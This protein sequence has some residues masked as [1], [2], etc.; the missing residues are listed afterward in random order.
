MKRIAAHLFAAVLGL[1]LASEAATF[2]YVPTG[3][4]NDLAIIDVKTDK[5]V[6]RIPE[7]ENAH[8]LAGSPKS[9]Y[10]VAGS[11]QRAEAAVKSDAKKPEA[12]SEAEHAAHHAADAEQFAATP[13]SQISLVDPLKRNVVRR[14]TVRGLTHHTAVTPDGNYAVAVHSGAGGISVIDLNSKAVVKE[15]QTGKSPN[16]AIFDKDGSHLFV[17]NAFSGNV[18]EITTSNWTIART[19]QT[20]KEPEHMVLSPDESKL[21]VANVADGQV[22]AIDLASGTVSARYPV[23][24]GVHGLDVSADGQTLVAASLSGGKLVRIDVTTGK[25]HVT[26]LQP[27]PYHVEMLDDLGKIYVSSRKEPKIWIVDPRSLEVRGEISIGQGVA[28]QMVVLDR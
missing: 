28:H 11:M 16:Y 21:Y 13:A 22:A 18:S 8:G 24:P 9:E 23:G 25:E 6:G 2:M 12:I 10:L 27:A 7:I 1:P 15:L 19:F 14:I 5:I 4:A 3:E 17:S 26:Q 20:G